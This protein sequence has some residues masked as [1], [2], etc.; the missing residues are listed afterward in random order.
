MAHG[1]LNIT[2]VQLNSFNTMY[3][4]TGKARELN[5]STIAGR[6]FNE[7]DYQEM[8]KWL[9][10][11]QNHRV[12]LFHSAPYPYGMKLFNEFPEQTSFDDPNPI[13][14]I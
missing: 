13:F 9:L 10:E 6:V 3:L 14:S 8:K 7:N 11:S 5:A 12:I 1:G 2:Y 4:V